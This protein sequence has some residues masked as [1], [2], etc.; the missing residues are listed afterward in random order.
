MSSL[1]QCRHEAAHG[2][3]VHP[4]TFQIAWRRWVAIAVS[5]ALLFGATSISAQQQPSFRSWQGS[6]P[7]CNA[8]T[9]RTEPDPPN[10]YCLVDLDSIVTGD[11]YFAKWGN[12][13]SVFTQPGAPQV[14]LPFTR[15]T[16]WA[17][18]DPPA[19]N[20]TSFDLFM[21]DIGPVL[22]LSGTENRLFVESPF[23]S[24]WTIDAASSAVGAD[25]N[26]RR[27]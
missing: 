6:D 7:A 3:R 20:A 17:S 16:G 12:V 9:S 10:P 27:V 8:K 26:L 23:T 14:V 2:L 11:Y 25:R 4:Q 18:L 21:Q 5:F 13:M 22:P 19:T 15:L 1:L 24:N